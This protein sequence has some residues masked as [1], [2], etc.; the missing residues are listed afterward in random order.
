MFVGES[1]ATLDNGPQDV[2]C[3][4]GVLPFALLLGAVLTEEFRSAD[5]QLL[6]QSLSGFRSWVRSITAKAY[7]S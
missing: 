6:N 4:A 3:V 7:D 2:R 1:R 5:S